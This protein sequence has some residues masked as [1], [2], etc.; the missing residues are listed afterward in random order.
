MNFSLVRLRLGG[1][2]CCSCRVK[3][4]LGLIVS[5]SSLEMSLTVDS[6][7]AMISVV[8]ILAGSKNERKKDHIR[9]VLNSNSFQLPVVKQVT[10][11][12]LENQGRRRNYI[13]TN[14]NNKSIMQISRILAKSSDEHY[15]TT[16]F[17]PPPTSN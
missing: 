14:Q 11:N 4:V 5:A 2:D 9:M 13:R 12:N 7:C 16:T 8:G 6:T 1:S 17:T 15:G 3:L 10:R